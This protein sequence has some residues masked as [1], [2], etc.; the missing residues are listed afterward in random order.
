MS[1]RGAP[2]KEEVNVGV[3]LVLSIARLQPPDAFLLSQSMNPVE[4][5]VYFGTGRKRIVRTVQV[6]PVVCRVG[7]G[8]V[9]VA[10]GAFMVAVPALSANCSRYVPL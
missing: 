5:L 9:V 3:R 2:L 1:Y 4:G 10:A 6:L 8:A 7:G